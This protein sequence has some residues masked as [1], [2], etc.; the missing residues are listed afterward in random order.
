MY[1]YAYAYKYN[2]RKHI[3]MHIRMLTHCFRDSAEVSDAVASA[4]AVSLSLQQHKV[5]KFLVSGTE[6]LATDDSR[7][8]AASNALSECECYGW[9]PIA[10][11]CVAVWSNRENF[12]LERGVLDSALAKRSAIDTALAAAATMLQVHGLVS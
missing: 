7:D 6:A 8:D 3:R 10:G 1:T 4:N 2:I 11:R 12:D 9:D 5:T